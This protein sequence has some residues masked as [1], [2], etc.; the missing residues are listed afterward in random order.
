MSYET[1]YDRIETATCAC[2]NGTVTQHSYMEMDDWNRTRSGVYGQ[3][4]QC[5]ECKSKYHIEHITKYFFQPK[6]KGDG[7]ITN[8]YLVPNGKT[9][10][11]NTS[12]KHFVFNF[13]ENCVAYHTIAELKDIIK[14]MQTNKFSTRLALSASKEVHKAYYKR[15]HK[16]GLPALIYI[17]QDCVLN[18]DT[19]EW[20][21]EKLNAFKVEE[22]MEIEK[23]SQIIKEVLSESFPIYFK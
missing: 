15:Y 9:A 21:Y 3:E 10:M 23:N 16:K 17:L 13:T 2:G 11:L 4:I 5:E 12:T 18:Y 20:T 14:D 7:T 8:Y 6:W 22:K 1:M 19:Y